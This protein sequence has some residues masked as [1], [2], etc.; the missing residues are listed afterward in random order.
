MMNTQEVTNVHP[1]WHAFRTPL[2]GMAK[3]AVDGVP[4]QKEAMHE[5]GMPLIDLRHL[6]KV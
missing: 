4:K 3:R 5:P 6:V 1:I 2:R